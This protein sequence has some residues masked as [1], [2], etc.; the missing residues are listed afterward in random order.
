MGG[1]QGWSGGGVAKNRSQNQFRREKGKALASQ[2][3]GQERDESLRE[4]MQDL[5]ASAEVVKETSSIPGFEGANVLT[6]N[7]RQL[8]LSRGSVPQSLELLLGAGA[9]PTYPTGGEGKGEARDGAQVGS[10]EDA[11]EEA[12]GEA[13][14]EAGLDAG[15][16]DTRFIRTIGWHCWHAYTTNPAEVEVAVADDGEYSGEQTGEQTG[17]RDTATGGDATGIAASAGAALPPAPCAAPRAAPRVVAVIDALP[18]AGHQFFT[19][20]PPVEAT[21][22]TRVRVTVT[23]SFGG[24]RVYL[25][26]LFLF[27]EPVEAVEAWAR[28]VGLPMG[29][30]IED[31]LRMSPNESGISGISGRSGSSLGGG[32]GGGGGIGGSGGGGSE[33]GGPDE[34]DVGLQLVGAGQHAAVQS[35][36]DSSVGNLAVSSETEGGEAARA[37]RAAR[38]AGGEVGDEA[39]DNVVDDGSGDV[40]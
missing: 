36:V 18:T 24:N 39:G 15:D 4:Q 11:G 7:A 38:A 30:T 13:G 33:G 27:Q 35:I 26:K 9:S 34:L 22:T 29:E 12:G 10:G 21:P 8:W 32:G 17:D 37:A 31:M 14:E 28:G 5:L 6:S 25:N 23:K 40:P 3:R 19:I 20:D 1:G 2:A 16:G